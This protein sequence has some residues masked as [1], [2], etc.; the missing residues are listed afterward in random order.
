MPVALYMLMG[1]R[2]RQILDGL[3]E[4]LS[5]DN[6]TIMTVLLLILG[7]SYLNNLRQR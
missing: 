5:Y 1:D 3:R 4:W 7:V 2:S 6:A